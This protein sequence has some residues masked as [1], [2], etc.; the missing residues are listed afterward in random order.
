MFSCI[1]EN[2]I[3]IIFQCLYIYIYIYIYLFFKSH[4]SQHPSNASTATQTTIATQK[5]KYGIRKKKKKSRDTNHHIQHI[6][7][8]PTWHAKVTNQH[9]L[10]ASTK[11]SSHQLMYAMH[12]WF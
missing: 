5:S 10:Y 1:P 2:A 11:P 9:Q 6:S 8:P 4:I 7:Q 12:P 3:K